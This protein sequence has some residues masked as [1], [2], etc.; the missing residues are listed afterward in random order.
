[1]SDIEGLSDEELVNA[2][3]DVWD[4]VRRLHGHVLRADGFPPFL[5]QRLHH[6]TARLNTLTREHVRRGLA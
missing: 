6:W 2:L 4:K 1:M 5:I 3:V